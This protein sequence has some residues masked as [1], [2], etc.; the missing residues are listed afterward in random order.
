M[1]LSLAPLNPLPLV[2]TALCQRLLSERSCPLNYGYLTLERTRTPPFLDCNQFDVSFIPVATA[3]S[4]ILRWPQRQMKRVGPKNNRKMYPIAR[5]GS[6]GHEYA[7]GRCVGWSRIANEQIGIWWGNRRLL[8][9]I[10]VI[11]LS[12]ADNHGQQWQESSLRLP[13]FLWWLISKV[14]L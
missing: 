1:Q 4:R 6:G 7:I 14:E 10:D 9:F 13:S 3:S 5:V 2:K 11:C 8:M 12:R